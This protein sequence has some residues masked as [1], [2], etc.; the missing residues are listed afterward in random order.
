MRGL[1]VGRGR[2]RR[3]LG[4]ERR[5]R[6]GEAAGS[7]DQERTKKENEKEKQVWHEGVAETVICDTH[8]E[9]QIYSHVGG[10]EGLL[11]PFSI[12][13]HLARIHILYL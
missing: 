10:G 2:G 7:T 6:E 1:K 4:V 9:N 11:P 3:S 8:I 13:K 5:V 12:H